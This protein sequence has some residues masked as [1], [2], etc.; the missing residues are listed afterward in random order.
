MRTSTSRPLKIACRATLLRRGANARREAVDRAQQ[1]IL[2]HMP[3]KAERV[4]ECRLV[5]LALARRGRMLLPNN[6]SASRPDHRRNEEF[7]QHNRRKPD[8]AVGVL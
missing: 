5:R 6:S 8:F 7:F 4:E 2:K 1:V 3:L